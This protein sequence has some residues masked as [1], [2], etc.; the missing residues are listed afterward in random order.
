MKR[1]RSV[2]LQDVAKLA[3]VSIATVSRVINNDSHPVRWDVRQ[4]VQKAVEELDYYPS[5]LGRNLR[6]RKS[7]LVG[8]IVHDIT[9]AYFSEITRGVEDLASEHGYLVMVCNTDR[10]ASREIGYIRTL[11]ETRVIGIILAGGG[12]RSEEHQETLARHFQGLRREHIAVVALATQKAP[13]PCI[14]TDNVEIGRVITSYLISR[15]HSRIALVCGPQEIF[16]SHERLDGYKKALAEHGLSYDPNLVIWSDF[17]A[18]GGIRSIR[19]LLGRAVSFTAVAASNDEMATGCLWELKRA[20]LR[21][22][23]QVSLMGANNIPAS[24]FLDPPLTTLDVPMYQMG[25][26]AMELVLHIAQGGNYPEFTE[27][28]PLRL[29]ERDSVSAVRP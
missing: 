15:G 17:T 7:P 25:R 26:R 21:V 11:R 6:S 20:G 19:E 23:E 28:V 14:R 27:I 4:R 9:D 16:T 10:N 12:L 3:G 18:K 8:V 22:P 29:V 5:S 13:F 2:T 1:A 24:S